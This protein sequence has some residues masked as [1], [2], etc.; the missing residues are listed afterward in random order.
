MKRLSSYPVLMNREI[1]LTSDKRKNCCKQGKKWARLCESARFK[2]LLTDDRQCS[3]RNWARWQKDSRLS[4]PACLPAACLDMQISTNTGN[5]PQSV[6]SHSPSHPLSSPA[7]RS[8]A[9]SATG[10]GPAGQSSVCFWVPCLGLQ[11]NWAG[12]CDQTLNQFLWVRNRGDILGFGRRPFRLLEDGMVS[13]I[14]LRLVDIIFYRAVPIGP[15]IL[16][17]QEALHECWHSV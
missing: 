16:I 3:D 14:I 10:Q 8:P 6:E 9:P 5:G 7:L 15:S 11:I 12:F 2:S 1:I 13:N 4:L 17:S